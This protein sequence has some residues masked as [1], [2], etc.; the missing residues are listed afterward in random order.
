ML[1]ET[2][3]SLYLW[4][5][6]NYLFYYF[7]DLNSFHMTNH[8]WLRRKS[9]FYYPRWHLE[10]KFS[11]HVESILPFLHHRWNLD[12]RPSL[13]LYQISGYLLDISCCCKGPRGLYSICF[14]ILAPCVHIMSKNWFLA[15]FL[16][17]VKHFGQ[18]TP[19]L[20]TV[21]VIE[22]SDIAFA[23]GILFI[24][25]LKGTFK[26]A[27]GLLVYHFIFSLLSGGLYTSSFWCHPRS[28]HMFLI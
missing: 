3:S 24:S 21:A 15:S 12:L 5:L 22:L 13:I 7:N 27:K 16:T 1:A 25:Y 2:L 18:A 6:I 28:L 23:V 9:I 19:L 4:P 10:S 26:K 20:L 17:G 14:T 8:S 11:P